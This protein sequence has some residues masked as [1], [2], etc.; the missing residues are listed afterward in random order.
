[1]VLPPQRRDKSSGYPQKREVIAIAAWAR[2]AGLTSKTIIQAHETKQFLLSTTGGGIARFDYDNDGW[3]DIFM[4]NGWRAG[5]FPKGAQLTNDL[6]R[7]NHDGTLTDV[8]TRYV[9]Q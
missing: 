2:K 4:V 6:S 1:M 7:Y 8:T 5:R 3:L 9:L